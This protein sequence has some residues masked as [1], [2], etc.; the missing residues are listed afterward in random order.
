MKPKDQSF[1][2]VIFGATGNLAQLKLIPALYDLAAAGL[3]PPAMSIVGIGRKNLTDKTFREYSYDVL[4]QPNRHHMHAIDPKIADDLLGRMKYVTGDM[5]DSALYTRLADMFAIDT[6]CNNRMFYLATYPE[7]YEPIFSHLK[8]SGLNRENCGWVR[9]I[10]EKPIGTDHKSAHHL[11][12]LLTKYYKEDQIYRLDHYLGKE[13]LQNIL[14]FRFG[15]GLYEHLLTREHVDH[16][17]VTASED[18]TIGMRGGYYD[19]VGAL[20]D[21]GQNHILQM[22]ALATMNAP[23][24]FSNEAITKQRISL[25][26]SL[27]PEPKHIVFGQYEGYTSEPSVAK[28]STSDTFFAFKT[29]INSDRFRGVPIYVRAGK[30]LEHTITEV[31]IVFKVPNKRL[32]ADIPGGCEPNVLIFRI[33]PNEG[34]VLRFLT[35]LPGAGIKLQN[36]YMQYCYRANHMDLPDPYL[37]LLTDVFRADQTFFID[38]PEVEV[39]WKFIDPLYAAKKKPVIYKKGTW[40]PKE[41]DELIEKDGRKWLTP[42]HMFCAL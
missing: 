31:A 16:I 2:L 33:Q 37:R 13:T 5:G 4:H 11:N 8:S 19:S 3:L 42:S 15:N 22:I 30:A 20:K 26:D 35:K 38:A 32:F 27:V 40:G 17:Q 23:S 9:V 7:L 25:I 39:Q 10:I 29:H 6:T 21:V 18:F 36:E 1:T 28:D 24:S 14:T 41:A 34:I 12:T